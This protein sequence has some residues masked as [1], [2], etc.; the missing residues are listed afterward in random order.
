MTAVPPETPVTLAVDVE[1]G[2][3]DAML[4]L[5]LLQV[6]P[7]VVSVRVVMPPGQIVVKPVITLVAGAFVT[8]T[9]IVTLV[10][11]QVLVTV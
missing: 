1:V 11:P 5:L 7:R 2:V 3:T 6:P 4:L 9:E 8:F 10:A